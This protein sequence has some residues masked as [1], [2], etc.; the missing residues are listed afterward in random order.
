MN[1]LT[2]ALLFGLLTVSAQDSE[3][4]IAPSRSRYRPRSRPGR[5]YPSS[6]Y[7]RGYTPYKAVHPAVQHTAFVV[8]EAEATTCDQKC[9]G[10]CLD[11]EILDQSEENATQLADLATQLG[12]IETTLDCVK[13]FQQ[14]NPACGRGFGG[15]SGVSGG[16]LGN[17]SR[18]REL[19]CDYLGCDGTVQA[20]CFQ[21]FSWVKD[22]DGTGR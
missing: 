5:P 4:A 17:F 21:V 6:P 12:E 18:A 20:K 22:N 8:Q 14:A 2:L 15:Y 11:G 13:E 10:T 9:S 7:H 16:S 1:S 3:A 19:F